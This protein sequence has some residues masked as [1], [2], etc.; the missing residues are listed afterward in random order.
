VVVSPAGTARVISSEV[1]NSWSVRSA[2]DGR[3]VIV[4]DRAGAGTMGL[5]DMATGAFE[6]V[7]TMDTDTPAEWSR[8]GRR[9]LFVRHDTARAATG[10]TTA[11][12]I[13][14]IVARAPDRSAPDT[15]VFRSSTVNPEHFAIGPAGRWSVILT[16]SS[17][18]SRLFVAPTD[19]LNVLRPL[20]AGAGQIS[21]PTVSP[22]GRFVAYVSD[23]TGRREVYL[24][25][26]PGPGPRLRVSVAGATEVTWTPDGTALVY[27]GVDVVRADL[28]PTR[29]TVAT[30]TTL[31]A[32]SF[33][34]S[35]RR[36]R[37]FDILPNGDFVF[38]RAPSSSGR[39]HVLTD[40]RALL[41][42]PG[43][44]RIDRP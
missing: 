16:A 20:D 40:W 8:D 13:A 29:S 44:P 14:E 7:A 35:S 41:R 39:V 42:Q 38:F 21:A 32:N 43:T 33:D 36:T 30:R 17:G 1:S 25:P 6:P 15:V 10:G 18:R 4:H 27:R 24:Q 23:E 3:R 2:P 19:S 9:V 31:F 26:L 22:D 11:G 37:E 12:P 28:D 34:R 5:L